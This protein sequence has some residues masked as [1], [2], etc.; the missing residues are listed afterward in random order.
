[1]EKALHYRS[2]GETRQ[3]ESMRRK[4]MALHVKTPQSPH[5]RYSNILVRDEERQFSA[6]WMRVTVSRAEQINPGT[7]SRSGGESA[8]RE[9][10]G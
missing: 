3:I 6:A 7:Q 4:T 5:V 10:K 8:K 9:F 1:M 2:P